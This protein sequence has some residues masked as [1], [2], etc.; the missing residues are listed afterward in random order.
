M[1]KIKTAKT[2]KVIID[3]HKASGKTIVFTNGCFDIL[4]P[5]HLKILK[6]AKKKGDILVVGLNA[7]S[8]VRKIKGQLRPVQNQ[9]ARSLIIEALSCVDYVITFKEKTPYALIK[10]LRPDILVKGGD[11]KK[12]E[13][14]G[15]S[16]VKKV[17]RI[18]LKAGHSTTAI[19]SKIKK[20]A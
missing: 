2:L 18:K 11:W 16:L 15:S 1:G 17:H 4:H 8:S 7:D 6:E 20:F 12:S 19:I 5:G 10:Q 9:K 13:I 3:K 14:I